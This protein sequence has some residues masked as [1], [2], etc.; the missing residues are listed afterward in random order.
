VETGKLRPAAEHAGMANDMRLHKSR[1]RFSIGVPE[2]TS[3]CSARSARATAPSVNRILDVLAFIED[4]S[5][6]AHGRQNFAQQAKLVII[7]HMKVGAAELLGKTA[8]SLQAK[9]SPADRA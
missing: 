1:S 4:H 5:E 7:E 9:F 8:I 2:S 3:R 6:P